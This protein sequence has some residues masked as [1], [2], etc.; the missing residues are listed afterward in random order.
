MI[1]IDYIDT[2]VKHLA[3]QPEF[4]VNKPYSVFT[5]S[6]LGHSTTLVEI[7]KVMEELLPL[8]YHY[9]QIIN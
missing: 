6:T 1:I 7:G 2:T 5:F 8:D 9:Q 4:M 3:C